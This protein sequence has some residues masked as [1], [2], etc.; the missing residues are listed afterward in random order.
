M[1]TFTLSDEQEE[2]M[3]KFILKHEKS[4]KCPINNQRRRNRNRDLFCG[5]CGGDCQFSLVITF[6]SFANIASIKCECGKEE[7]LG[8]V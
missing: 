3:N 7:F 6:T 1:Q 2:K 4:W 5:S 8:E